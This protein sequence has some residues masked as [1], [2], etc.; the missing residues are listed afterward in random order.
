MAIRDAFLAGILAQLPEESR[1]KAQEAIE[2]LEGNGLRQSDYSAKMNELRTEQEKA[3]ALY[4]SNTEWF[5]ANKTRLQEL[6]TLK[7]EIASGT[8]IRADG[9]TRRPE[10]A[11]AATGVTE[12]VVIKKIDEFGRD[13]VGV[14]AEVQNLSNTHFAQFGEPL[15]TTQLFTHPK[16]QQIGIRGVY[17][18]V[19]ADRLKAKADAA[20][21]AKED[22]IRADERTKTLAEVNGRA[23]PQY[24][25]SGSEA[26]TLDALDAAARSG[27]PPKIASVDD[28]A[29]EYGRLAA[30]R[31]APAGAR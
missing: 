22:Q 25:A 8:L 28:M 21:K 20:A 5:E 16:A 26:S 1:G 3:N 10:N 24:P 29:A 9:A 2:A 19:Y 11:P 15:D 7:G 12:E 13:A 31:Q 17:N 23:I 6:D 30:A 27:Q 14:I 18:I 4:T